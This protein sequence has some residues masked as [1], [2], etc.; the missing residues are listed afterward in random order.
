[1]G[2]AVLVLHNGNLTFV[3]PEYEV[4]HVHSVSKRDARPD[5]DGRG[6]SIR[7]EPQ[8]PT[9]DSIHRLKLTAFGRNVHLTL[10][11]TEGLFSGGAL[12]MWAAEPNS[13]HAQQVDYRELPQVCPTHLGYS[14]GTRNPGGTRT[15]LRM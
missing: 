10:Q 8:S 9:N 4:V 14:S 15:L 7:T 13:T 2:N 3:V 11:P 1:M 12:K 5:D 6:G